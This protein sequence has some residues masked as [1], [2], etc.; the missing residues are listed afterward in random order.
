MEHGEGID[1]F[2]FV[3]GLGAVVEECEFVLGDQVQVRDAC[4]LGQAGCPA[5]E[6]AHGDCSTGFLVGVEPNPVF[7]P[8]GEKL[9]PGCLAG[10]TF[11]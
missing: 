1:V 3:V 4:G 9:L 6:K 7:A 10:R 8:V 2:L 5:A 11:L